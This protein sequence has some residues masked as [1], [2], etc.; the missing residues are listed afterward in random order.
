MAPRLPSRP[1]TPIAATDRGANMLSRWSTLMGFFL[2]RGIAAARARLGGCGAHPL[3]QIKTP[4]GGAPKMGWSF[5]RRA[6]P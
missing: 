6:P 2:E 5:H 1:D 4:D 3:S